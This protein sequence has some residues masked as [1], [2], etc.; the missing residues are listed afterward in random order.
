MSDDGDLDDVFR[1]LVPDELAER[2]L[3]GEVDADDL[4]DGL[5]RVA[6]LFKAARQTA[7]ADELG[8][9]AA[10]VAAFTEAVRSNAGPPSTVRRLRVLPQRLSGKAAAVVVAATLMSAGAA[11]AATGNLP[12]PIQRTVSNSL[13]HVGVELPSPDAPTSVPSTPVGPDANGPA[14]AALCTAYFAG[15]GKNLDATAAGQTVEEF[16]T[17]PTTTTTSTSTT[18]TTSTSTTTT[19]TTSTSTTEAASTTQS[20]TPVGPD[21]NGPAKQGLC[22]AFFSGNGKNMEAI[23][24]RNL[25]R[26]ADAAG[27]T[28][29]EFCAEFN[30][31]PAAPGNQ[32]QGNQG[33]GNQ[34][35]GNQGQGNQGQGNQ[36]QGNQGNGNQGNGNGNGPPPS[37]GHP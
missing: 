31:N 5:A 10:T 6:G 25:F 3:A 2:V 17:R 27:Q 4:G 11:A 16:C 34:G 19:T 15:N 28:I 22:T 26:A 36:G 9:A 32:S 18:T 14:H 7:T 33:Q 29:E 37:H 12:D 30:P 20:E 35:Q 8:A 13:S 21:A 1:R 24:F 23:A